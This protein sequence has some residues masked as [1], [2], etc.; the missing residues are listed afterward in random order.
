M[1]QFN[2]PNSF[3]NQSFTILENNIKTNSP[4][5]LICRLDDN[6][7]CVG[8]GRSLD[9]IRLWSTMSDNDKNLWWKNNTK[10]LTISR[11]A[12]LDKK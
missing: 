11:S 8:C 10:N 12:L 7:I 6:N 4:C 3:Q 5:I 1:S 9:V 2:L